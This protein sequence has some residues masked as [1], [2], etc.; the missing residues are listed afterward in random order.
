MFW[1]KDFIY[2]FSLIWICGK[3]LK[4]VSRR[5]IECRL[6]EVCGLGVLWVRS[7]QRRCGNLSCAE[8]DISGYIRQISH[9]ITLGVILKMP[10]SISVIF[11]TQRHI[12]MKYSIDHIWSRELSVVHLSSGLDG[13]QANNPKC[14]YSLWIERIPGVCSRGSTSYC[15]ISNC[16]FF[17]T[18]NIH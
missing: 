14:I 15:L 6:L 5:A 13:L 17:V 8:W 16:F 7:G 4:S 3:S 10:W 2:I 11:R 9:I 1:Y 12:H 18:K